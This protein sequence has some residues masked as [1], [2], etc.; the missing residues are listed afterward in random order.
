MANYE[1]YIIVAGIVILFLFQNRI[2]IT[3]EQLEK[4]H[5][6]IL[7]DVADRFATKDTFCA[8]KEKVDSL[9]EKLDYLDEKVDK[10]VHLIE[11]LYNKLIGN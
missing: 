11:E 2:F 1:I 8:V 7:E 6:E 10:Q 9:D 4:K 3:P 5:R